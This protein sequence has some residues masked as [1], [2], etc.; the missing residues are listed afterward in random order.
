MS[1]FG[2]DPR[3]SGPKMVGS[4]PRVFKKVGSRVGLPETRTSLKLTNIVFKLEIVSYVEV[5][6][7]GS[8][9]LSIHRTVEPLTSVDHNLTANVQFVTKNSP[10]K[11]KTCVRHFGDNSLIFLA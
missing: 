9:S 5:D 10:K 8:G 2:P 7:D 1:H 6:H 3:K 11:H 4:G